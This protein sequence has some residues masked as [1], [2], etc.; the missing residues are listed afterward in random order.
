[1][2]AVYEGD[3]VVA[4]YPVTIGSAATESPVGDWKIGGIA[5]MPNFR[6]DEKMLNEGERSKDFHMLAPGPNNPVG[7]MWIALNKKGIGLHGTDDPDSIGRSASHGCV[8][9]ANW[10]IVRLAGR[11]KSG[12]AVSIQEEP[13]CLRYR[14]HDPGAQQLMLAAEQLLHKSVAASVR[15]LR[16]AGEVMI[17]SRLRRLA[18]VA[19][20]GQNLVGRLTVVDQMLRVGAGCVHR[21]ELRRDTDKTGKQE[22][23]AIEL[24]TEAHHGMEQSAGEFLARRSAVLHMR[25][26]LFVEPA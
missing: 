23:L 19:C 9:L 18:E 12:A 8:R 16:R 13:S 4:A 3:V 14:L 24:W 6:Y 21:E 1:M 11:V 20:D 25:A 5:K 26:Q 15:V 22:L 17:N 2:L 10:D 7:V